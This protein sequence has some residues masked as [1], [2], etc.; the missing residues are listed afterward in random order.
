MAQKDVTI[1]FVRYLKIFFTV[2][3]ASFFAL[4]SWLAR[5]FNINSKLFWSGLIFAF[6]IIFCLILLH[7]VIIKK[8]KELRGL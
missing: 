4:S 5:N 6:L 3:L 2:F 1:E 7:K 8:I